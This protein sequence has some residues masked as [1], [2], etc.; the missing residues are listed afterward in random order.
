[1][2]TTIGIK[3]FPGRQV[4]LAFEDRSHPLVY[5]VVHANISQELPMLS[6]L[7][8]DPKWAQYDLFSAYVESS[9]DVVF[10]DVLQ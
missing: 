8:L 6:L 3:S 2:T 10:V 4:W 1:M 7:P 9:Y 5:T